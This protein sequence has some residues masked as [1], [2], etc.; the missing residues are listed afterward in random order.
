VVEPWS[1]IVVNIDTYYD[2]TLSTFDSGGPQR[3]PSVQFNGLVVADSISVNR[4]TETVTFSLATPDYALRNVPIRG[5]ERTESQAIGEPPVTVSV[6]VEYP[7]F[8]AD[9]NAVITL[10]DGTTINP[11][12]YVQQAKADFPIHQVA[13]ANFLADPTSGMT[14]TDPIYHALQ[15]HLNFMKWWDVYL[16]QE[17]AAFVM[18]VSFPTSDF[19]SAMKSTQ[20]KRLGDLFADRKGA[21]HFALDER[22]QDEAVWLAGVTGWV[23]TFTPELIDQIDIQE[24]HFRV[25]QVRLTGVD[26]KY[27]PYF[28]RY[29]AAADFIGQPFEQTS[30]LVP[31]KTTLETWARRLYIVLNQPFTASVVPHGINRSLDIDDLVGL[32]YADPAGKASL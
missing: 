6:P 29:P 1:R 3:T 13:G 19:W 24:T 14:I 15:M 12:Q 8:F 27:I 20:E 31:D 17:T 21:L 2:E 30:M 22:F 26:G 23:M 11:V 28:V 9:P 16:L 7:L 18:P 32:V 10:P 5:Y 25:C 4:A